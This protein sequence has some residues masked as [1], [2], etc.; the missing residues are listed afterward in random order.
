MS[1]IER[2]KA[3]FSGAGLIHIDVPEWGDEKHPL[4]IFY[5]AS[6][7]IALRRKVWR[8]ESGQVVDGQI[9]CVRALIHCAK[10]ES[11]KDLFDAMDEHALTYEVD[12][13]VVSRIGAKIL[14]FADGK[15]VAAKD[16]ID[17]AKKS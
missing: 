2:A 8:D 9:A 7:S 5:P 16:R 1:T 11:G 12:S 3:H 15:S 17:N 10:D 4:R 13:D 14:G 6:L